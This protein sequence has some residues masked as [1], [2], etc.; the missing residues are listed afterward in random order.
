MRLGE[1]LR[2]IRALLETPAEKKQNLRDNALERTTAQE[3]LL[4][5]N[6]EGE[7]RQV[8]ALGNRLASDGQKQQSYTEKPSLHMLGSK[9]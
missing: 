6:I 5:N 8:A 3:L 9:F 2:D 1:N 7:M 4:Q